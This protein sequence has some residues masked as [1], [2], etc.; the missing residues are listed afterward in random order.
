MS[1]PQSNSSALQNPQIGETK[2]TLETSAVNKI[3]IAPF[4][5]SMYAAANGEVGVLQRAN[6]QITGVDETFDL[7]LSA[8]DSVKLLNAYRV[9]KEDAG[10]IDGVLD[11]SAGVVVDMRSA[12][13]AEMFRAALRTGLE[14]ALSTGDHMPVG[15]E[16]VAAK[17][18]IA[19]YLKRESYVD[20]RDQ[21][22]Y[23]TLSNLL[24][25]SD[26]M[27]FNMA[28]DVSGASADMYNK[29]N[30]SGVGSNAPRYRRTLFTQLPESNTE[31]YLAPKPEGALV[32]NLNA[33]PVTDINFLPLRSGDRIYFVF[34]ATVGETS[35]GVESGVLGAPTSGASIT[36]E[37][38][39][40]TYADKVQVGSDSMAGLASI[41]KNGTQYAGAS[42]TFSAPTKRRIGV[43]IK[44]AKRSG[45][46]SGSD[47]DATNTQPFNILLNKGGAEAV[48]DPS[49]AEYAF[50]VAAGL[51]NN[52]TASLELTAAVPSG[53][54]TM[55]MPAAPAAAAVDLSGIDLSGQGFHFETVIAELPA[56]QAA[57]GVAGAWLIVNAAGNK[58]QFVLSSAGGVDYRARIQ[59][60]AGADEA[61]LYYV[62]NVGKSGPVAL[63]GG[64]SYSTIV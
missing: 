19:D 28:L 32:D 41:G 44:V 12:D 20:T 52:S 58:N 17:R 10:E 40:A 50:Q 25:A 7:C 63:S 56:A 38:K 53:T 1:V 61:S 9:Y 27:S 21:L 16:Q 64:A 18:I 11:T 14:S 60:A 47:L 43:S 48:I 31:D 51:L 6:V 3:Y 49:G 24:E 15:A 36:R 46:T 54:H 5:A 4:I 45:A 55:A 26:L 39:D 59:T 2:I 37:V 23:D 22:A 13:V 8:E 42:L 33:E 62:S 35:M 57:G 29:M 30:D 34:D